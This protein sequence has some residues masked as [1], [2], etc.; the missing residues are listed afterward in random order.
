[1]KP[2]CAH[3]LARD[4][5][6]L[7]RTRKP[8]RTVQSPTHQSLLQSLQRPPTWS[9]LH[10]FPME[11]AERCA[12]HAC[13][14]PPPLHGPDA[15]E[16]APPFPL[17]RAHAAAEH[18]FRS[19]PHGSHGFFPF[20]AR[21]TRRLPSPPFSH[22]SFFSAS[23]PSSRITHL[24][25]PSHT[26]TPEWAHAN[27]PPSPLRMHPN[28]HISACTCTPEPSPPP[29]PPPAPEPRPPPPPPPPPPAAPLPGATVQTWPLVGRGGPTR[30]R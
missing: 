19:S 14:A 17:S 9:L 1:M 26:H 18:A 20:L 5:P 10:S 21:A 13:A 7:N 2:A 3:A 16:P 30:P 6:E 11:L 24:L 23:V 25:P 8:T 27:M 15:P 29:Q 4:W 22:S 12:S 28:P